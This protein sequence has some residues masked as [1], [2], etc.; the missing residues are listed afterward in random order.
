MMV[1]MSRRMIACDEAS[2]LVS[3]KHENRLGFRKWWKLKMHLLS[4]HLCRK[5]LR[6]IEQLN[7]AVEKYREIASHEECHHHLTE[8]A[9]LKIQHTLSEE[10]NSN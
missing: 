5:Y 1:F 3:Y 9:G 6:Q 10:L 8:E 4:C 7:I 2:F